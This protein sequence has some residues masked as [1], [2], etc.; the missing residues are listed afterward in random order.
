M[1]P[2][3]LIPALVLAAAC[4]RTVST[5]EPP[6]ALVSAVIADQSLPSHGLV[7]NY[8]AA[9]SDK[10]IYIVGN[11]DG[12]EALRAEMMEVDEYDNITGRRVPDGLPDFAGEVICTL[13][14]FAQWPYQPYVDENRQDALREVTVRD[15]LAAMD[16]LC[17]VNIYDRSGVAVKPLPKVVV[18][19]SPFAYEY[20]KY[21][22]DTLFSALGCNLQ[23][24][25]PLNSMLKKA[26][27]GKARPAVGVIASEENINSGVFASFVTFPSDRSAVDPLLAFLDSCMASGNSRPLDA[28]IIDDPEVDAGM[29]RQT[30]KRITNASNQESLSYG[31]LIAPGCTVQ[32]FVGTVCDECYAILRAGNLFTHN[33]AYPR[34]LEFQTVVSADSTIILTPYDNGDPLR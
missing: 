25:Y 33:I 13:V 23:V 4:S 20:G 16:T 32:D 17:F 21:D 29:V 5:A 30:L 11:P 2:I 12:C 10:S 3:Y 8:V 24:V 7:K 19:A 14:D 31:K 26:V 9:D 22:I 15:L 6:I 18:M 27:G 34:S 1:K 28:I